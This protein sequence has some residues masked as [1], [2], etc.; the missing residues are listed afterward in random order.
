M[1]MLESICRKQMY[2]SQI[3]KYLEKLHKFSLLQ[4]FYLSRAN[5][6]RN[7]HNYCHFNTDRELN[8]RN[9]KPRDIQCKTIFILLIF[10]V[11]V[12]NTV[13]DFMKVQK[14]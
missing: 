8:L 3:T 14:S 11:N 1:F 5:K 12:S 13:K 7:N 6:I 9:H 2:I 4:R 10:Y